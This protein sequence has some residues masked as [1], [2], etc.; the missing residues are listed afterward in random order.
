MP[1]CDATRADVS[2]LSY[3]KKYLALAY[4]GIFP[5]KSFVLINSSSLPT[6]FYENRYYGLKMLEICLK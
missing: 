2:Y 6:H 1:T 4:I 3:H 5:P